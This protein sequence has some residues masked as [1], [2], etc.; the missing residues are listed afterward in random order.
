MRIAS[1]FEMRRTV[2]A[3]SAKDELQT[4]AASAMTTRRFILASQLTTELSGR[5]QRPL[6]AA[7]HPIHCEDGAAVLA[8]GPL[9]RVVRWQPGLR[10][11]LAGE[12]QLA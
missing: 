4:M 11:E 12:A 1:A 10:A 9:Q 6:R 2:F 5:A 3:V 7:E 8:T